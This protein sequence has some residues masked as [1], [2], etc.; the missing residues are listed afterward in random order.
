MIRWLLNKLLPE[1]SEPGCG[2][3][4]FKWP[5][6]HPFSRACYLH[7]WEFGEANRLEESSAKTLDE[8]N[9]DMFNRW[10]LIAQA[11]PSLKK[12]LE[13]ADDICRGYPLAKLGG[14]LL[15][16]GRR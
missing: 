8:A 11:E 1:D 15:W 9:W 4:P 6:S 14:R 13:L 5:K 7:D 12:R 10:L 2:Y 16:D 3:G